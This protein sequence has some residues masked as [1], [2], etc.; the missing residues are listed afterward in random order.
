MVDARD[1][2]LRRRVAEH[3]F[4]RGLVR[5]HVAQEDVAHHPL[6]ART[7][8]VALAGHAPWNSAVARTSAGTASRDVTLKPNEGKY[9]SAVVVRR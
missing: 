5:V 9:D 1:V 8:T 4:E 2:A 3:G 6:E 7:I